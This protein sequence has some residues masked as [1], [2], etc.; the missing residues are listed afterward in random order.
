MNEDFTTYTEVDPNSH[1]AKTAQHVDFQDYRNEDAHL[2]KDKG[3]GFFTNFIHLLDVKRVSA[4]SW[5]QGHPWMVSND[6]DDAKGLKDGNK[7]A[8]TVWFYL[9]GSIHKL[10]IS[11]Y[12]NGTDYWQGTDIASATWY[13]LKIEKSGTSFTCKVYSDSART[14]L[15]ATLSL[16]LHGAWNFRYIFVCNTWNSNNLISGDIDIENLD[17]G[18]VFPISGVTRDANGNPLG[19][20]TV[21]LFRTSDKAY[22]DEKTSDEN[23]NYTFYVTDTTTQY[24]IRAHKD[25]TPNVFGTTERNLVGVA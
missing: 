12:Y 16:T 23:G 22:M 4:Q 25:G 5:A 24:F 1:I 17:L 3:E 11:E 8:L 19:G 20:C 9:S 7:T 10:G 13:Y 15:L 21:W 18:A 6:I 14:N 2:Y